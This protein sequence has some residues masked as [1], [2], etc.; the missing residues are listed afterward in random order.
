MANLIDNLL[1]RGNELPN[2]FS[3]AVGKLIQTARKEAGISQGELAESSY[4]R[5]ASISD[6]ENGKREISQSELILIAFHLNKPLEY[7]FPIEFLHDDFNN[8][9]KLTIL[10]HELLLQAR[11]LLINDLKKLIAQARALADLD[12]RNI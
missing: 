11:R 9:T 4:L 7:F 6:I 1:G 3:L 10:E 12:D 5:Q 2:K 8:E